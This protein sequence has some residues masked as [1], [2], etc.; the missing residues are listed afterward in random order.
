MKNFLRAVRIALVYRWT[1][2]I[3]LGSAIMIGAL[4]GANIGTV[5]PF[6][7]VAFKGQ[8]LHQWV[9]AKISDAKM[10]IA[11]F[12]N[13]W[14][15]ELE[16]QLR[17]ASGAAAEKIRADISSRQVSVDA[18][19]E[20][21]AQAQWLEPYI[22]GW[23]PE[24]AFQTLLIIAVVLL[25]GTAVKG[26]FII[27]NNVMEDRLALLATFDLRKKLYR[28]ALALDVVDFGAD[29]GSDLMA[30]FTF[31]MEN[32][33]AGLRALFGKA[34][35]E[36]LKMAAC[37]IGAACI[38]WRLLLF[39]LILA[40]VMAFAIRRIA[41]TLKRAN[42]KAMEEMSQIYGRLEESF[43]GVK[44]V[45]AFTMEQYERRQFHDTNKKYYLKAMK[46]AR[47]EALSRPITEFMGVATIL[48][49]LLGG[50]YLVLNNET[51]V[52][53]I[54]MCDRPLGIGA[55]LLFY[56]LLSGVSDPARKLTDVYSKIQRAAAASDR[57]F[58]LLDRQA[59]VRDPEQPVVLPKH[60]KQ[61]VFKDVSFAYSPTQPVLRNINL[62]VD[63]GET[64]A[65]VGPNGCGK[66]TLLNLLPRFFD[67]QSGQVTVDGI[68]IRESR[69]RDLRRQIG[70][71]TQET[72]LF[73]DTIANNIRYG[74]RDASQLEIVAA[75]KS[76]HADRFITEKLK[77]GYET[78]AG[79][80]G[81]SLSG[82]QRQRIALARAILRDPAILIL[83]EAT[84]QIDLESEQLIHKVL[85]EFTQDRTTFIITHRMSTLALADRILV[86]D[87]GQIADSGS[88]EE[89][90][91]RCALYRRL[92]DL[93]F[94][95]SA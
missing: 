37:L 80:A 72:L 22:K 30:R 65:I 63:Y 56:G 23:L 45:K 95:E 39:S 78:L 51:H 60:S 15:P 66:S 29:G 62:T 53:G 61:I 82:G 40:P 76:A 38:C 17:N 4:W 73:D 7:E 19:K 18:A 33:V 5:Y 20:E 79:S 25:V 16:E 9:D 43:R 35:R 50:A 77:D 55:L 84:S 74:R 57:V 8:S 58:D 94:R 28:N 83:D 88:H 85:E 10:E 75:A 26:I 49:A 70:L 47:Y 59:K 36:P 52:L 48:L 71:V 68:D 64:I 34:V 86:M 87:S 90:L 46:I 6:V 3:A 93:Q 81:Q 69:L 21:L 92:H 11:T 31:D 67:P 12:E 2:A 27:I 44:V 54:R 14:R 91:Q 32:I 24:D 89:L 41:K 13:D 42:R 1:V